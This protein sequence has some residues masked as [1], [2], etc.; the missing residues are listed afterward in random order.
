MARIRHGKRFRQSSREF[1]T[2]CDIQSSKFLERISGP[3]RLR[4]SGSVPPAAAGVPSLPSRPSGRDSPI[5]KLQTRIDRLAFK[6][7]DTEDAFRGR[8]EA[9]LGGRIVP[10]LRYLERIRGGPMNASWKPN[11]YEVGPN[12]RG[13]NI[14]AHR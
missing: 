9:V 7:E 8:A 10:R 3:A 6:G 11:D 4:K 12:F 2:C 14:R 5:E 13:A 1:G